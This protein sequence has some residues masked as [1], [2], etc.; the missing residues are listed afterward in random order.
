MTLRD[1]EKLKLAEK[2]QGEIEDQEMILLPLPASPSSSS[3]TTILP[4]SSQTPAKPSKTE[5]NDTETKEQE[6][7]VE[8]KKCSSALDTNPVDTDNLETVSIL[9]ITFEKRKNASSKRTILSPSFYSYFSAIFYALSSLLYVL[10]NKVVLTNYQ[11]VP[12]VLPF[13]KV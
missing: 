2:D 4:P 5:Q 3:S 11:L 10:A 1:L 6:D 7:D 13:K 8:N 9:E 12:F